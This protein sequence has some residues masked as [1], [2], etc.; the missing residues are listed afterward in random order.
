[1]NHTRITAEALRYRLNLVR[2]PLVQDS[3]WDLELMAGTSVAAG[4]TTVDIAIR[5]I[6]T[7]WTRAGLDP[8]RLCDQWHG[9]D[10]DDLFAAHP[11]LVD[12]LDDIVRFATRSLAA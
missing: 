5:Q 8:R 1:M 12:A 6:A 9:P 11:E 7:A 2:G 4:D 3:E 10:V